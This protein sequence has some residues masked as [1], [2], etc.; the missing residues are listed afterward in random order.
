MVSQNVFSKYT[1]VNKFDLEKR[2]NNEK[3]QKNKFKAELA[4][5][6]YIIIV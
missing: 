3:E 5:F 1:N 2:I 6:V 4:K